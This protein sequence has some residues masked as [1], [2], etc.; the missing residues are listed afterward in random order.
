MTLQNIAHERA[1]SASSRSTDETLI[2]K[3]RRAGSMHRS[4]ARFAI[5]G[6]EYRTQATRFETGI[7]WQGP[8]GMLADWERKAAATLA[9][10]R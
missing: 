7:A 8:D 6:P 9:F 2:S 5:R 10:S 3:G 4:R 1:W